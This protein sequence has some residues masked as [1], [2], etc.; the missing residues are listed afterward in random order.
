MVDA[1]RNCNLRIT[2]YR[3]RGYEVHAILFVL[4]ETLGESTY[5]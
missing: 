4:I 2:L 5:S 3:Y 1:M